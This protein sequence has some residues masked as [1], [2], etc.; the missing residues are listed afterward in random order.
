MRRRSADESWVYEEHLCALVRHWKVE[1]RHVDADGNG[2][3]NIGS[4]S[5]SVSRSRMSLRPI[6][7]NQAVRTKSTADCRFRGTL[8][9]APG[10]TTTRAP[11]IR[12][13]SSVHTARVASGSMR[14]R[15]ELVGQ[16]Q[17]RRAAR[18]DSSAGQVAFSLVS[19]CGDKQHTS[20]RSGS[21]RW[22]R[23]L[24]SQERGCWNTHV[25]MRERM[26]GT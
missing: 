24:H 1:F 3:K 8:W 4:A 10:F 16:L 6:T 25:S 22:R 20:D 12:P 17:M 26:C 5:T 9:L 11:D 21:L 23:G 14:M 2:S 13:T 19:N 7:M 18:L 15:L